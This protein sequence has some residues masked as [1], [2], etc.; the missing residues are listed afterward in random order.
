MTVDRFSHGAIVCL[1]TLID[2]VVFSLFFI[3]LGL[4]NFRNLNRSPKTITIF[5]QTALLS[6]T[7]STVRERLQ[8]IC[9]EDLGVGG[10]LGPD[11]TG[12]AQLERSSRTQPASGR[13]SHAPA[14]TKHPLPDSPL[15]PHSTS[16]FHSPLLKPPSL[17]P[18]CT[19]TPPEP[20]LDSLQQH[21]DILAPTSTAL[22]PA[23][24][25]SIIFPLTSQPHA[26]K[27]RHRKRPQLLDQMFLNS[28]STGRG[29]PESIP[30]N[31]T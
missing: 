20:P 28:V 29:R 10:E 23:P 4:Q 14:P 8:I 26:P 24:G 30:S 2:V 11:Q 21:A 5:L 15:T 31:S 1:N 6:L 9:L 12:R 13:T 27:L 7:V 18:P 19:L 16:Q 22:S 3:G 25:S 17:S